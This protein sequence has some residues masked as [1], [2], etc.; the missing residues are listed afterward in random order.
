MTA[1]A[2]V[3]AEISAMLDLGPSWSG[4]PIERSRSWPATRAPSSSPRTTA[5]CS[6]PFVALGVVRGRRPR[7]HDPPRRGH[8]RR[9][10]PARRGR[11]GQRR[12]E[13][14]PDRSRSPG[15]R[16]TTSSIGS[17]PPRS[18]RAGEVI[19]MMAVWRS[20]ARVPPFTPGRP[21]VPRGPRRSRPPSPSRT[22]G[23]SRK[24]APRRRPPSRPTRPSRRSSRR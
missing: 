16:A 19:G 9:P 20:G 10:G 4:S 22:R 1:L 21:V 11:D 17:W 18:G 14:R 5:S 24:A 7:R 2:D 15:P 13:R 6:A 3:A 8:H 12:R 23:S